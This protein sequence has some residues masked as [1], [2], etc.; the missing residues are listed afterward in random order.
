[1]HMKLLRIRRNFQKTMIRKMSWQTNFNNSRWTR[2]C[3]TS[4]VKSS[5]RWRMK[6]YKLYSLKEMTWWSRQH[7][8]ACLMFQLKHCSRRMPNHW[9]ICSNSLKNCTWLSIPLVNETTPIGTS[10][11]W[12]NYSRPMETKVCKYWCSQATISIRSR[13]NLMTRSIKFI[14]ANSAPLGGSAR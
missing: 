3:Q 2:Q 13:L 6:K 14:G 4:S 5:K 8:W 10:S 11:S 1:M 12:P 9:A 7:T